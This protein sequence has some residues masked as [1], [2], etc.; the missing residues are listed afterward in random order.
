MRYRSSLHDAQG[1]G[2]QLVRHNLIRHAPGS[3]SG[4]LTYRPSLLIGVPGFSAALALWKLYPCLFNGALEWRSLEQMVPA[5][6][7]EKQLW[8]K[9][10]RDLLEK[11]NND[12]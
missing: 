5:Q 3:Q 4:M 11:N 2:D 10:R 1:F 9:T 12:E 7:Q 6:A 8:R